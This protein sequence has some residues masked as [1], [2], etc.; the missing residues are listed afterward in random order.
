MVKNQTPTTNKRDHDK[1]T[2][3]AVG[4]GLVLVLLPCLALY[5]GVDRI[6]SHP[7]VGL[8]IL[9]VFGIMVL[10]GSLAIT[11][12]LFAR[13]KLSNKDQALALPEGS[14]RA[15]IA[16]SLIVLFAII[17]I[18]LY[19]S[20]SEPYKIDGLTEEEKKGVLQD[21]KTQVIAVAPN[22]C[23]ASTPPPCSAADKR[24]AVHVRVQPGQ[25][26]TDIAKQLLTLIGTLM[27][28][29]T[30]FYFASRAAEPSARKTAA[31]TPPKPDKKDEA[32]DGSSGTSDPDHGVS[33]ED[34]HADGCDVPIVDATRDDE[35]PAAKGGVA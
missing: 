16:L 10:L 31:D 7:V 29:V 19:Q 6:S 27:T 25:E 12:A 17:S 22:G 20:N 33:A 30:S 34:T 18:M 3:G 26:S 2:G 28:A 5:F 14:V 8:P 1:W 21:L 9:A 13:L 23:A 4:A 24:Y 35:L 11:A 15:A 32:D